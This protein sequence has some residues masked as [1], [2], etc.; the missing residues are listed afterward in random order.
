MKA[1]QVSN[2][3]LIREVSKLIDRESNTFQ[4]VFLLE[5]IYGVVYSLETKGLSRNFTIQFDKEKNPEV[6]VKVKDLTNEEL[7]DYLLEILSLY[8][9]VK[10]QFD[11]YNQNPEREEVIQGKGQAPVIVIVE[12]PYQS[13]MDELTQGYWTLDDI[14]LFLIENNLHRNMT[15]MDI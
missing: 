15:I 9:S 5:T 13:Q 11:L 2:E 6:W 3:M 8:I 7:V 10:E 1:I 12:N 14:S 4:A